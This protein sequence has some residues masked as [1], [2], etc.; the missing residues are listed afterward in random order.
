MIRSCSILSVAILFV[1]TAASAWSQGDYQPRI[2]DASKDAELALKGFQLP[3]NV[4]GSLLAAEPMLANP[5]CF[6]IT[7]DGRVIVCETFRQEVGVEDNRNHMNWLENDLQLESVEERAAMFRRYMGD[8]VKKWAKEHDR[9][10]MLEDTDG[11]GTL[12]RDTLFADGFNDIVDG[13][14][15]G[16]IE[17]NGRIYYTCIP[18]LWSFADTN[19]DG[20][21]DDSQ[22]LHHGY[23]VRVAFRGHDMHGLVVGPDGRIYF[24]IGDRGYNVITKEGTRLKRV[25]TGAVFRCDADGSH[26]EVFAYGLRNPQELAF[27]DNGNLFTG[28]NNSDSGDKA[29]WVYVVQDGDTGWRMY[30]QYLE[31][32]G[33]WNRERI[34]YPYQ[35]DEET[36]TVQPASILPPIANLGDGPSGLTFY[37]GVGLPDRYKGHFFMADFRGTAGNSGIR[38]F[39]NT[40]K[41]ATF[42][43]YDSHEFLWSILAT[44]VTFAPDASMVVSDWV[45]GWNGEGK[46]RLY[47]FA[48]EIDS[49]NAIVA[50][51]AK[52]LGGGIKQSTVT[53]LVK[54]L[55][56]PDRRVRFEAQFE[57]VRRNEIT[58]LMVAVRTTGNNVA[59]LHGLWGCWQHGLASVEN[60]NTVN[61]LLFEILSDRTNGYSTELQ[62]QTIKV[63]TDIVS[64]HGFDAVVGELRSQ[65][66]LICKELT[67]RDE[68]RLAGFAATALGTLGT[69]EDAK[70]LLVLLDRNNNIDPVVRHQATMGIV[71]LAERHP[72]LLD[73]LADYGGTPGRLAVLLAMRRHGDSAIA[74][75][76]KD[77]DS[78]LVAEAARAIND[79]PIEAAQSS[80]ADLLATPGLDDNT[81]RRSLNACYRRGL[82]DDAASVA[83][84]AAGTVYSPAIR[85][86]AAQLL[87]TWN[88]P[89]NLDT[90]TGRWRPLAAREVDRLQEAVSPHLP[91]MLAGSNELRQKAVDIA[92]ELGIEDM[93]PALQAILHDTNLDD[94]LRTSAFRAM[95]KL[96]SDVPSV[97]ESGLKDPSESVRLAAIEIAT[98]REPQH[99][100]PRLKELL[101]TGSLKAQQTALRL[102]GPIRT[103]E[104][105][106]V[107][108]NAFEHLKTLDFSAGATLDLI[109]AAE[110]RGTEELKTAVAE[111]RK[112]QQESGTLLSLWNECL[113]G[114]DRER[115]RA[116]FFGRS[117]AACRRCHIVGGSGGEVGPDLSKVGKEKDRNY[118]LEAM[119]DPSAKIAKGFE[120]VIIVTMEGKIHSG[121]LKSEDDSVV[122]LMTPTGALISVARDDIDERANGLSGMPQDIAK[123]LTRAEIRDLVEYLTT[124]QSEPAAPAHGK[125][126]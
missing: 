23:G 20:V 11:D 1:V 94:A 120:T 50:N 103:E 73:E 69:S 62:T 19:D 13:T 99:A 14:G 42:E 104:S 107:L 123:N 95:A 39:T 16:V 57:L 109:N 52:L 66:A 9:L 2:A 113:E 59:R 15:A 65:L 101:N 78:S 100:V 77:G 75:F 80:L 12:D 24:S 47:R 51:S 125:H 46:G 122:Q 17:H 81:L 44:D 43:L 112:R 84:V 118:L 83:R 102:L 60:A 76:L 111:F 21:A 110:V 8:D 34:W 79:E 70:S 41:G 98:Q 72:G 119:V 10:R 58:E 3:E 71:K 56:H 22:V 26:L 55:H 85:T 6:T 97:L 93:V 126:E 18:N 29:R 64:R 28:D 121:I 61:A 33:P 105:Q 117:A 30:Y 108:M 53:D 86:V 106:A 45:N 89:Q 114:G 4:K 7:N 82:A 54:L 115:G 40:P 74:Q 68:L 31:D 116:L 63:M 48:H 90:V 92:T 37:P 5:V 36:S 87:E 49:A 25:D 124:L 91:G 38:S 67:K 88:R 27:D 35:A 32:R 96:S